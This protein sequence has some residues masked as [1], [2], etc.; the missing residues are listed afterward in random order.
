MVIIFEVNSLPNILDYSMGFKIPSD[1]TDLTLAVVCSVNIS[2]V[3]AWKCK[4]MIS[5]S[6]IILLASQGRFLTGEV[7]T[8]LAVDLV[9][10]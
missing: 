10:C 3:Q 4:L 9:L 1:L 5:V 2:S 8:T 7:I 6:A